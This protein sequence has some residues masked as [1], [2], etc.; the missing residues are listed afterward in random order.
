MSQSSSLK[1]SFW[2]SE[3]K[4]VELQKPRKRCWGLGVPRRKLSQ[5]LLQ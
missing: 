1:L 3:A 2:R 4:R 5:E